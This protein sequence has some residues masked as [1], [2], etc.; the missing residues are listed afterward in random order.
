MLFSRDTDSFF[1]YY[2]KRLSKILLHKS[3]Y[4]AIILTYPRGVY[5]YRINLSLSKMTIDARRKNLE[6]DQ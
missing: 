5:G 2:M 6:W 1:I 3:I 4:L